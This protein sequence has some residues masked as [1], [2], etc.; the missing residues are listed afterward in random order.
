[1]DSRTRL[2]ETLRFSTKVAPPRYESEFSDEV[3]SAWRQQGVLD[4]KSPEACLRLDT[5]DT[6]PVEWRRNNDEKKIVHNE[7]ELE[8][9]VQA[10]D[11][12]RKDRLPQDWPARVATWRGRDSALAIDPWNEGFFQVI[13]IRDG[14]TL[15]QALTLLC[16]RPDLAEA[17]M[18]HY[19]D[20]LVALL[21][22]ILADTDVDLAVFYEPI[23]SNHGPVI[24]PETYRR[25]VTP[26]LR[27]VVACL[28]RHGVAFRFIW[29]AGR[30]APLI[31]EWLDAGVN[32]LMLHRSAECG[33]P[34][35]QLRREY[36]RSLRFFGGV[37]WHA[38][39]EGP[40]ALDAELERNVR[41]VLEQGGYV[42]H[43]DDT[44]RGYMSFDRYRC[45]RER[46]DALVG[47]VF[48]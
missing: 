5:W 28:D 12:Q 40:P 4:E 48:A 7:T 42:P 8:E 15:A 21:D 38:V 46:L 13:G 10:Y 34:Y 41:P 43:L 25:F 17:Q 32:G 37:S 18:H 31:P 24:S 26:G 27:R 39:M 36:D 29:S 6:A 9:F 33:M 35:A 3:I 11:L 23:A 14:A 2:R 47:K 1:M 19:A 30:V 22:R 45:Y 20:Y 44:V 16:E